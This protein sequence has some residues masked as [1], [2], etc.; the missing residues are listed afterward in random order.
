MKLT[1]FQSPVPNFGDELNAYMWRQLL[2]S[3]FLDDDEG[4]LFVGIGS[5]LWDYHPKAPRKIVVGSGYGGY[6]PPPDVHDGSWEIVFVRGPR[7]AQV[8]SVPEK[9]AI[10]DSA[11]LLR[12]L[13]IPA[14]AKDIAISFMPHYES[15]DRGLW[16][17]VCRLAGVHL[18][19]PTASVETILSEIT[20]TGILITEAMHGAIV[21][22][23]LRTPWVAVRPI[24]K[25]H[26]FK[27]Y[28]WAESLG[29]T[30]RPEKLFPSSA[31]EVWSLATGGQGKGYASRLLGGSLARPAN[32]TLI[33]IAAASLH[34]LARTTPQLSADGAILRVTEQA[35]SALDSFVRRR[36][37]TAR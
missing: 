31:R 1:Y 27:W 24:H 19:D 34:R 3:G 20:R 32:F 5:I 21:A 33:H 14:P 2:P 12:A 28:D 8:L 4:E 30:L 15:L 7:T 16:R 25:Q 37:L 18:I 13:P 23:A 29:L 6:S 22:D 35:Q 36:Q 9:S 10:T 17:E 26:R 11:I